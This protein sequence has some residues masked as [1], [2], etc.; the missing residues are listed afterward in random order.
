MVLHVTGV[1]LQ[2]RL[3]QCQCSSV[4]L[5]PAQHRPRRNL[6]GR[7]VR[8]KASCLAGIL[9]GVLPLAL[10]LQHDCPQVESARA[11]RSTVQNSRAELRCFAQLVLSIKTPTAEHR[12]NPRDCQLCMIMPHRRRRERRGHSWRPTRR[13]PVSLRQR[14]C[15]MQNTREHKTPRKYV[16]PGLVPR[17]L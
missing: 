17:A 8:P 2:G 14:N 3:V 7:Q 15:N 5:F 1:N 11:S 10:L 16:C 12:K 6:E 9:G 13:T 4:A